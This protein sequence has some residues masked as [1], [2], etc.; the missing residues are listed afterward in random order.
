MQ[1]S[2]RRKAVAKTERIDTRPLFVVTALS[3]L[4]SL[5]VAALLF[6]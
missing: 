3:V 5:L 6:S 4:T 1:H 2:S